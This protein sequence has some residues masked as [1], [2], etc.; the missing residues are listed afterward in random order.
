M[1]L[2][3]SAA[4]LQSPLKEIQ[5]DKGLPVYGIPALQKPR[6]L[7][8]IM[9][10]DG[11]LALRFEVSTSD[12]I[13]SGKTRLKFQVQKASIEKKKLFF[14]EE[15]VDS[16]DQGKDA[17]QLET[18]PGNP[19]I[20]IVWISGA[21]EASR[22]VIISGKNRFSFVLKELLEKHEISYKDGLLLHHINYLCDKEIGIIGTESI[23]LKRSSNRFRFTVMADPQGGDPALG[24]GLNTR[25]K[26]HNAFVEESV[27]LTRE[28]DPPS[29]FSIMAGDIVDGQGEES[30]FNTM[31]GFFQK[32][33]H[34][35]LFAM[36]NH[37]S[38][39]SSVFEPG[40]NQ[41]A[42]G[43][44]YQ[45]QARMNGLTRLLYSFNYGLWHFIIW[46]DPLRNR[47]WERHPHYFEW[48]EKD[49]E[50]HKDRPVMFF[51]HIPL[52]PIGIDPLVEYAESPAVKKLLLEILTRFG[53]VK[54]VIS[55]H[56][57]IPL[58]ACIKTAVEYKGIQ[59]INLPAAGYRP[60]AFGEEDLYG[61]P[62][63]GILVAD[64]D[65][66]SASL[67]YKT[68]TGEEYFFNHPLRKFDPE[69]FP[70]WL[71]HRWELPKNDGL[72]NGNFERGLAHWHGHYIYLEDEHPSNV[73]EIRKAPDRE[74]LNALYLYNR[75]R[76]YDCPGQDRLP[77]S[78]NRLCQVVDILPGEYPILELDYMIDAAAYRKDMPN[79]SYIWIEGYEKSCK[80]L[81]IAYAEGYYLWNIEMKQSQ[82]NRV[83]ASRMEISCKAGEWHRLVLNPFKDFLE[84]TELIEWMINQVDR[85]IIN[86]G[87]WTINDG[88]RQESGAWFAN[89]SLKTVLPAGPVSTI[90][91][92]PVQ[93]KDDRLMWWKGTGHMAGEH[94]IWTED[95]N[96]Y[97]GTKQ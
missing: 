70:L 97:S 71:N 61:G 20:F 91:G 64:I 49:L 52:H 51:Q 17:Y 73:R 29:L 42:F 19:K 24:G 74:N 57:H 21:S 58:R 84:T 55:G 67:S 95:M 41:D 96:W 85:L 79:G 75:K 26:I 44:Y 10:N 56:V 9:L 34:P 11:L 66:T 87:V 12:G 15:R 40:Y 18:F 23:G 1:G 80:R 63:Q 83:P 4:M 38:K 7:S 53:N 93:K 13:K 48:L 3:A 88:Y 54:Y 46:P 16:Y 5:T 65:G 2:G 76:G 62:S 14:G 47:F 37:E 30:S 90:N 32:L 59:F 69:D 25:V 22:F 27:R 33:D 6:T 72:L 35:V 86:L 89:L 78:I 8:E 31:H 39:Y 77:Q 94:K 60:R 28:L 43:N 92:L 68:V 82:L 50:E 45:A 81:N 36:G